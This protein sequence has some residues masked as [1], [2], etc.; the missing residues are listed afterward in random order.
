LNLAVGLVGAFIAITGFFNDYKRAN[1]VEINPLSLRSNHLVKRE[2]GKKFVF[3]Y[4]F[5]PLLKQGVF[6]LNNT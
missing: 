4:S 2:T 1:L 6:L 3:E 5:K